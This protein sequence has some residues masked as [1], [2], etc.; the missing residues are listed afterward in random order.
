ME[1]ALV[2]MMAT[3]LSSYRRDPEKNRSQWL[4]TIH[5]RGTTRTAMETITCA[6]QDVAHLAIQKIWMIYQQHPILLPSNWERYFS[7]SQNNTCP[8]HTSMPL[9]TNPNLLNLYFLIR[10]RRRDVLQQ[11]GKV[12]RE[13]QKLGLLWPPI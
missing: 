8:S 10:I 13:R 12:G 7:N 4:S 1:A 6:F 9:G 2:E 3:L 11:R 5:K